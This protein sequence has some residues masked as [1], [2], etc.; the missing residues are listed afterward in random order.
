MPTWIEPRNDQNTP[1]IFFFLL[2]NFFRTLVP[3]RPAW[4][5]T[6]GVGHGRRRRPAQGDVGPG[7]RG[8]RSSSAQGDGPGSRGSQSTS[9][10]GRQPRPADG[11]LDSAVP[12]LLS[13]AKGGAG[14]YTRVDTVWILA[15]VVP[16][17]RWRR[18]DPGAGGGIRQAER[19]LTP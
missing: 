13:F 4:L 12:T 8:I 16:S 19:Q 14:A 11:D 18:R 9:G 10:H 3:W 1:V 17:G 7:S 15:T 6:G 2:S 5:C